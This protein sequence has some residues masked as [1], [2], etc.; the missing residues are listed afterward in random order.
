AGLFLR[1]GNIRDDKYGGDFSNRTRFLREY[2][3]RVKK[4]IGSSSFIL[5]TRINA[6]DGGYPGGFGMLRGKSPTATGAR[7][8][9]LAWVHDPLEVEMLYD[10]LNDLGFDLVNVSTG[11]PAL[12]APV[13]ISRG[14]PANFYIYQDLALHAR[15][16]LDKIS[17][18]I[19]VVSSAWSALGLTALS[20]GDDYISRGIDFIGFGR[21]QICEPRLPRLVLHDARVANEDPA[22][23][24]EENGNV[25]LAC[26]KCSAGLRGKG[27]VECRVYK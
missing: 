4:E 23:H 5:A 6:W 18:K 3:T 16:Y 17:S 27:N 20:L 11:V 9:A 2:V 21:W 10:L 24:V 22:K 14:I 26:W 13:I 8:D 19:K 15:D 1:P 7:K 12:G 25:C